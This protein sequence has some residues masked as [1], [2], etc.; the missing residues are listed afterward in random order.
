M[1]IAFRMVNFTIKGITRAACMVDDAELVKIPMVGPLILAVNHVNF[2]DAPIFMTHLQPRNVT[3]LVKEE[4]WKNPFMGALFNLWGGIPIKR[5]EVDRNAYNLAR[6][7]LNDGKILAIAPEG[8][9]SKNGRLQVGHPGITM[10]AVKTNT[11]ILPVAFYGGELIWDNIH[12]LVRTPFHIRVGK[13]FTL[14]PE[15]S[16]NDRDLRQKATDQIMYQV[17]DLLPENYRGVY[18]DFTKVDTSFFHFQ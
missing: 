18:S 15:L 7:S 6:T 3:A 13:I 10:I 17:A 9:R 12:R 11:P 14:D 16:L 5:G 1:T 4:T 2:L 8:T